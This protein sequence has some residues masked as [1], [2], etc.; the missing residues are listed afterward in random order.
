MLQ[1]AGTI[2]PPRVEAFGLRLMFTKTAGDHQHALGEHGLDDDHLARRL[3]A[4]LGAER[5]LN[6]RTGGN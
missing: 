3:A 6:E 4:W 5:P 1:A 2:R